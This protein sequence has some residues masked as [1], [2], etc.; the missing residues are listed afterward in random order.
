MILVNI[1]VIYVKKNEIQSIGF[2]T[3]QIAIIMPILDVFLGNI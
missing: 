1:I 2:T 3:V